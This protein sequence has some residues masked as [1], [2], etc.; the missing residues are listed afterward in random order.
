M[1]TSNAPK[2]PAKQK[3]DWHPSDVKSALDKIGWSLRQLGFEHGYTGNASFSEVFRKPW[4]RVER[5]IAEA[6]GVHPQ[7]IWPSRYDAS[8]A[9]NRI[10]G[11]KIKRPSHLP[12][13]DTTSPKTCNP[14]SA[15]AA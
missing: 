4:P 2:K 14:Q 13:K 6:I 3:A 7:V 10:M 15:K 8:G 5:I 1:T 12:A 11:R 9:P